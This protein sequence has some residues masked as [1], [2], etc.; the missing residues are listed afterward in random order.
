MSDADRA[1]LEIVRGIV[2]EMREHATRPKGGQSVGERRMPVPLSIIRE[3]ERALGPEQGQ[4]TAEAMCALDAKVER[5]RAQAATL[6]EALTAAAKSLE[7]ISN[8]KVAAE[9]DE[10][11]EDAYYEIRQYAYSRSGIARAALAAYDA[12]RPQ[13]GGRTP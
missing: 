5:Y 12:E 11:M 2:R 6:A 3:L 8:R 10:T 1:N 7:W 13:G 9:D 4:Y